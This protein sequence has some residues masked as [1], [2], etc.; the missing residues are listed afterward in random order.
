VSA[1]DYREGGKET[2]KCSVDEGNVDGE[3]EYDR[4]MD[5]DGWNWGDGKLGLFGSKQSK[6]TKRATKSDFECCARFFPPVKVKLGDIVKSSP[7][8]L[9]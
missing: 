3:D 6:L 4:F 2:V 7:R 8:V 5:Q 1:K 9:L